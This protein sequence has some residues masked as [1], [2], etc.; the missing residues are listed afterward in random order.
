MS[1]RQNGPMP[2]SNGRVRPDFWWLCG[3]CLLLVA[4]G[5]R[6]ALAPPSLQIPATPVDQVSVPVSRQWML[7]LQ[8]KELIPPGSSYS[9]TAATPEDEMMLHMLSVGIL[10]GRRAVPRTY[11]GTPTRSSAAMAQFVVSY[12]CAGEPPGGARH[13]L[14]NGC[15]WATGAR[16]D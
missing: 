12:E 3:L 14:L 13:L 8:A 1:P 6:W 5:L 15:L 9:V 2:E 16:Q 11:Y 10:T 7:L 4:G